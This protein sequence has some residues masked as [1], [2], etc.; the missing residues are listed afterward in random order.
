MTHSLE[1]FA[2]FEENLLM[3]MALFMRWKINT[4]SNHQVRSK[5]TILQCLEILKSQPKNITDLLNICKRARATGLIGINV[6]ITPLSKL[7]EYLCSLRLKS[8]REISEDTI[9]DFLSVYTSM[10]SNAS[11]KNYRIV[12]IGFFGFI[13]KRN[14][15]NG[16]SHVFGIEL[17]IKHLMNLNSTH[18]LPAYLDETELERFLES[19]DNAPLGARYSTRD[20]LIIKIIVY[21]GVRVSEILSL[22]IKDF[23]PQGDLWL[24]QVRGKGNKM[25]VVMIKKVKIESLMKAWMEQRTQI[26]LHSNIED[27]LIFCNK[28]G[29]K[30]TQ[31]RI[32]QVLGDILSYAGI[33]KEKM[34]AHM[35]R[36]TF[37]TMLYSKKHDLVLVQEALGHANL[38]TSRIYTHF[39]KQRLLEA[40]SVLDDFEK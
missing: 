25:R 22:R 5:E 40:A 36:H 10:L 13:D 35:L 21:T 17:T 27:N 1:P 12:L 16:L 32:Y 18:K 28:K 39:D 24:F 20:K 33:K 23:I 11:K 26:A 37:A 8:M 4:L 3:W 30:L 34:G 7:Y 29:T 15:D 2:S 31:A 14:Q 9:V 19:L 6:F 38:N